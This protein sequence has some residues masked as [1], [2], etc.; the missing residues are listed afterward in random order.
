MQ[1]FR[2]TEKAPVSADCWAGFGGV[3]ELKR[4]NCDKRNYRTINR[5][6]T[7]TLLA[8]RFTFTSRRNTHKMSFYSGFARAKVAHLL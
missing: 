5:A 2:R 4:N 6:H 7:H 1:I 8:R 3:D